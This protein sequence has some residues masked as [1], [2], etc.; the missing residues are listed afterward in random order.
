M[1]SGCQRT[2]VLFCYLLLRFLLMHI[3][4]RQLEGRSEEELHT[5]CP[6]QPIKQNIITRLYLAAWKVRKCSLF[7][8]SP[9]NKGGR[10][11]RQILGKTRS[12]SHNYTRPETEKTLGLISAA[13]ASPSQI[14]SLLLLLWSTVKG[15]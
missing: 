15:N 5:Q 3:N 6:L 7:N 11:Q 2:R 13:F 10:W 9:A 14:I 4:S 1:A 8:R 12:F